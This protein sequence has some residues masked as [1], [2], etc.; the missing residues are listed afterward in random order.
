MDAHTLVMQVPAND[1]QVIVAASFRGELEWAPD[2]K[3][4]EL[5]LGNSEQ[6]YKVRVF[7]CV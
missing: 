5:R 4:F 3:K 2:N 6:G 1:P 7:E